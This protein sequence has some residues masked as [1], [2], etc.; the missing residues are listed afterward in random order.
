MVLCCYERLSE[1]LGMPTQRRIFTAR[2]INIFIVILGFVIIFI[3][4]PDVITT[5]VNVSIPE[6]AS[7]T[8]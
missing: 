1:M 6:L 7:T 2:L 4:F 8:F 5:G 3:F